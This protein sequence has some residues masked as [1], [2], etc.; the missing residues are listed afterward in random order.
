VFTFASSIS[1]FLESLFETSDLHQPRND[2][3]TL[4]FPD[5]L[6]L[7]DRHAGETFY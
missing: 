5:A 3:I 4:F 1:S 6:L 2:L 7:S